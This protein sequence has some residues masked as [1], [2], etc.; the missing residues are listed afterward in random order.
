M[1]NH[2]AQEDTLFDKNYSNLSL[3]SLYQQFSHSI[4]F[5]L[6]LYIA[7]LLILHYLLS[8]VYFFL[9]SFHV[10]TLSMA[11]FFSALDDA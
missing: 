6:P 4:S 11:A 5:T 1:K 10:L 2:I 7:A 8:S 3:L 9:N